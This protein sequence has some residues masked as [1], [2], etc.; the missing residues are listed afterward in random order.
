MNDYNFW[1]DLLDTFQSSPDW[2]KAVWL[3]IPPGFLLGLVA[4]TM[5]FRIAAKQMDQ[6]PKGELI[7]SIHR[8]IRNQLHV[9]SHIPVTDGNP[10]L[11]LLDPPASGELGTQESIRLAPP[12]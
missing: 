10:A 1:S 4:L 9:V 7:Y 5:R 8:D 2:I 11:L 6:S 3:L 12:A